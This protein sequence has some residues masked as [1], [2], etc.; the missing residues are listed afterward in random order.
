MTFEEK[1]RCSHL[2]DI[3][4]HPYELHLTKEEKK[5]LKIKFKY[6]S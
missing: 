1:Q 6:E 5:L 2:I 3:F 4:K